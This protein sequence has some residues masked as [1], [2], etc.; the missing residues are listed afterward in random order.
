M[1]ALKQWWFTCSPQ[2]MVVYVQP[3]SNDGL[4][5]FSRA[6]FETFLSL[7]NWIA[8]LLIIFRALLAVSQHIFENP[9]KMSRTS[10]CLRAY[11]HPVRI[12]LRL[13]VFPHLLHRS[14]V[15]NPQAWRLT[16]VGKTS[17]TAFMR[18][19]NFFVTMCLRSLHVTALSFAFSHLEV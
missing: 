8:L 10:L 19:L 3:S 2:A 11:S 5:I 12:C 6:I 18:K 15:V 14:D 7:T 13:A 17:Q 1:P 4:R 9:E 16:G